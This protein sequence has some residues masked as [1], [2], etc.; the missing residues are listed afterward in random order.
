MP[1]HRASEHIGV[2]GAYLVLAVALTYPIVRTARHAIPMDAQIDGWF[3]GDGDPWHYLWGFWLVKRAFA[4]FPPELLWTNLVFFPMGFEIPFLP[5]VGLILGPAAVLLSV[6]GVVLTYNLLWWLSFALA[7][8][9]MYLL[10]RYLLDD[11]AVAFACGCLFAFSTYRLIHAVEHLPI[12]MAS[13]LVPLFTLALLTAAR[14]PTTTRCVLCALVL[15][16]STGISW[17]S[18]ILLVVFL[19]IAAGVV[20]SQRGLG[21]LRAVRVRSLIAALLALGVASSPF[22]LPLI[23]SPARDSIVNRP[24]S[25]STKYSADLLA[26]FVPSPRNPVFGKLTAP[27]YAR[28]TGNPYE[29][30]VYLGYVLLVLAVLGVLWSA[31]ERTR[32][33]RVSAAIAFVLALGPFLHVA[34]ASVFRIEDQP[35]SVPL[36]YLLLHYVPFVRGARVPSRFTELLLLALI[37]L[38]GYALARICAGFTARRK[39]VLLGLL[40][41]AATVETTL[42]PLPAV[43]ARVPALYTEIARAPEVGSVLELPLDVRII[44]YHYYQTVHGRPII[45]G[46]P[47]RPREKYSAYPA[48]VPLIPLLREPKLLVGKPDPGQAPRD[49]E[50][51]AAFFE[52][53]FVIVHGEYLEAPVF[54]RLDRFVAD[55]FP[56]A[57]RTVEGRTVTYGLRPP[58]PARAAWPERYVVDFGDPRREFAVL[59]GWAAEEQWDGLTMQWSNDR[60]SSLMLHLDAP[61]PRLLEVRLRPLVS[62][63]APPQTVTVSVN[64]V[65][66]ERLVLKPEWAVYRVSLPATAFRSG[67]NVLTFEYGHTVVPARDFSR[68]TDTRMLAV[69]FDYL[70]LT[71]GR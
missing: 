68:S 12:V 28:F 46:N 23:L 25:E 32:L 22:V 26:F 38:A 60:E 1:R 11:R 37:V 30:T 18:T 71:P 17:Y 31:R 21:A 5:G 36:P 10:C 58:D 9:A 67:R 4:T 53:R 24:L 20:L 55:N 7:G 69:A 19:A 49:A 63:G 34:G 56:H 54:E 40:V 70:A 47:V 50:R 57:W 15:A 2:F 42:M 33:F 3:P 66:R 44:K 8:Y 62:P 65:L 16:G 27:L 48:G 61:A 64:G 41:A 59:T 14:Q 43:S 52:I 39:A 6:F 13:F 35:L 45:S 51:L 29:Q